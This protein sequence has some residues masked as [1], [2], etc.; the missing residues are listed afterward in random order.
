MTALAPHISAFF[1]ERLTLERRASANTYDS[2]AYAFKL[3][4]FRD[5]SRDY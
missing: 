3:L 2:Y 1:R 5:V 4:A